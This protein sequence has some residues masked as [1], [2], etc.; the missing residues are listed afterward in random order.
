MTSPLAPAAALALLAAACAH[1][2]LP[3][4]SGREA[5]LPLEPV[6]AAALQGDMREALRRLARI[7]V[8]ELSGKDRARRDCLLRTF[9]ERA[10]APL[11]VTG[12]F[13]PEIAAAY[14]SYWTQVLLQEATP[15]AGAAALE[16]RLRELLGRAGRPP[17][18]A[19]TLGDL[20]EAL[21]PVL[22]AEGYHS[23]RG[24]TSPY[25]ELMLWR[26][27]TARAYDVALPEGSVAVKVVFLDGFALRGWLGFATCGSSFSGGWAT[28]EALYC[29]ADA[30]DTGS[31]AFA[32]S[33]LGH[34]GQHFQDYA[35]FPG[36]EQPE[37]EYRA[38]L[39]ELALSRTTT[40]RLLSGFASD[41]GEER[42]APHAH[43][44]RRVVAGLS[45]ALLGS[46]AP[47]ADPA[48]WSP[49]PAERVQRAARELLAEDSR[50]RTRSMG[51]W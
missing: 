27:E 10:P 42:A 25:R 36:L 51:G 4:G 20:T 45:R 16:V 49:I 5:G 21:E 37:L 35:R 19:A 6:D 40:H 9:A 41:M 17:A 23:I 47:V 3:A 46:S 29:V 14:R 44:A 7:P 43:A 1:R 13:A 30:Y 18:A 31:E 22:L 39:A 28:A 38:K 8:G 26:T 2:P 11:D 24:V 48:A 32:V 50:E 12:A 33:Y 34:E 15:A